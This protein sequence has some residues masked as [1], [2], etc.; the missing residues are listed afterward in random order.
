MLTNTKIT[1]NKMHC[2]LNILYLHIQLGENLYEFI[3]IL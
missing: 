2:S 1:F 3:I